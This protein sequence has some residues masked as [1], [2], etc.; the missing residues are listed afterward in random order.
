MNSRGPQAGAARL[1]T[2]RPALD[3]D[4]IRA[5]FPAL[6]QEVNGKPLVYLDNA[7]TTHKPG[8]VIEAVSGFYSR[9]NSNVHRGLHTLSQRATTAYEL[10]RQKVREFI[11]AAETREIVFL[12]GTTE[13]INLVAQTFGRQRIGP[14][15][16]IVITAMEHHSN[17][18]PWQMLCQEKGCRLRV[19]PINDRGEMLLD[20]FE[21]ALGPRTR[22]VSVVHLSNALGTINPVQ[23]IVGMAHGRGVPVLIDGAQAASHFAVDVQALGCDF[24]AFS[25]HKLY[26]PTGI[27]V[28]YGKQQL[29]RRMPPW[30]TGGGMIELVTEES[31]TWAQPPARFEAGTPAVAEAIGLAAAIRYLDGLGLDAIATY[32]EQVLG[33]A[34]GRLA[35]VPGLRVLG[36]APQRIGVVSFVLG[37]IHPHDLGTVLDVAGVAV[38]AGHHCAQPLM[39]T[40]R[41]PATVRASLGVYTTREDIDQL[42]AGLFDALERF[43]R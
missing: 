26:G 38:R 3:A 34:L 29:L 6:A 37:E 10:A 7:A 35:E 39:R 36:A 27:G 33:Y 19:V 31:T 40:L 18:V 1:A 16:E 22:L 23:T 28:L 14:G 8:A 24:Y 20:E 32:E 43:G 21:R 13:A 4:R 5:D 25:G 9:D 12:R 15:D 30:Q 11:N 42:I 41:L 17:I 2:P